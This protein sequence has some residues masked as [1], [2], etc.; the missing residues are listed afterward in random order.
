[1]NKEIRI[2]IILLCLFFVNMACRGQKYASE[3]Y[4]TYSFFGAK[5]DGVTDDYDAIL[6]C[7]QYANKNN[8]PVIVPEGKIYIKGTHTNPII[9][10]TSTDLSKCTFVIDDTYCGKKIYTFVEDDNNT[11]VDVSS[12][13]N[14]N[15]LKLRSLIIPSLSAYK[16]SF[17]VIDGNRVLG[18]RPGT[19]ATP[20]KNAECFTTMSD[21]ILCDGM[22]YCD[23]TKDDIKLKVKSITTSPITIKFPKIEF[24]INND[25]TFYNQ[26]FEISRNNT[27]VVLPDEMIYTKYPNRGTNT[28]A[29]CLIPF[30][31]CYGVN[32]S[33]GN[34]E[35]KGTIPNESLKR[36]CYVI[37]FYQC[38]NVKIDNV[39]LY[40]GWGA[41]CTTFVKN[42]TIRNS[43][44]NRIDNHFGMSDLYIDN[45]TIVGNNNFANIGYGYGKVRITNSKWIVANTSSFNELSFLHFREDLRLTYRGS[46]SIDNVDIYSTIPNASIELLKANNQYNT[47]YKTYIEGKNTISDIVIKN[48]NVDSSVHKLTLFGGYFS[49][50]APAMEIGKIYFDNVNFENNT[51]FISTNNV[52]KNQS[53]LQIKE[54]NLSNCHFPNLVDG[55]TDKKGFISK[56]SV[57]NTVYNN[58]FDIDAYKSR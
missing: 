29:M 7:H 24:V 36:T 5:L 26:V 18:M 31:N 52:I 46:I 43:Y 56:I 39:A 32:I 25:K 11:L 14:K 19:P 3:L 15:E 45:C 4:T 37:N 58:K 8:L 2:L 9:V 50:T 20:Y 10:K 1:M 47:E 49:Q 30:R 17:F 23:Y 21:G 6:K 35:N 53:L 22:L 57:N 34:C 40:R 27:T 12:K 41:I 16:H 55:K 13:V 42:F 28:S 48:V 44:L 51:E 38:S 54:M 33:G